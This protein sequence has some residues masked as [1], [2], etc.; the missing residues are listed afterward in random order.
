[1]CDQRGAQQVGVSSSLLA[2][3]STVMDGTRPSGGPPYWQP[4]THILW[5]YGEPGAPTWDAPVTVV[6]DDARGLVAWLAAGTPVRKVVRTDGRDVRADPATA[7]TA[8]RRQVEGT[9]TDYD[10]LRIAPTGQRWSAW[11]FFAEGDRTFAGWYVNIESPHRRDATSVR[12]RDHLLDVWVEPDRTH[13]RKDEAELA[14]SV[15]HGRYTPEEAASFTAVAA[16]VEALLEAW[17]PPFCDG[18]ESFTP[19]PAWPVPTLPD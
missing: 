9:W 7:F 18:W 13:E 8:P 3:G 5:R 14:A 15:E 2:L 6:R 17:G 11:A 4:G 1:M 19:D 12:S 10:V 16:E